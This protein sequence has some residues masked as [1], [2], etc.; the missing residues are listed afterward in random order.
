MQQAG[1]QKQQNQQEVE[2]TQ[3]AEIGNEMHLLKTELM[4]MEKEFKECRENVLFYKRVVMVM[5][6][7]LI[8][9]LLK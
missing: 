4:N 3:I 7:F 1:R 5:L 9:Y 8:M 6:V 2:N